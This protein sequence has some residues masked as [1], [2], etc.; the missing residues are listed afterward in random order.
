MGCAAGLLLFARIRADGFDGRFS[1]IKED[2][3]SFL[4]T[5]T[6]QGLW[7]T[8]TSA[9]AIAAITGTATASLGP[10]ALMGSV[11]WVAGFATEAIADEQKKTFKADPE[12]HGRFITTGL[13]A[14]SRH[15]NY[16]GE[17]VLWLGI[18]IIAFPELSG[19]QYATLVSPVFVFVLLNYIS[20]VRM[21]EA[22]ADRRW[23][24]DPDY[25][26]YKKN[27]PALVLLPPR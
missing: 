19:W 11:L 26:A 12:N 14:W 10:W 7:V 20:G 2:F 15:P 1:Q 16:F 3:A 25:Q 6:L 8:V 4:M 22:R 24:D 23:G 27:T 17:I 5:W 18:A 9:A 13:W 21:L